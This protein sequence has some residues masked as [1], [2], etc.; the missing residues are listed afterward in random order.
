MKESLTTL[1]VF[2]PLLLLRE[3]GLFFIS[4]GANLLPRLLTLVFLLDLV[5]VILTGV[6]FEFLRDLLF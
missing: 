4:T 6:S 1:F 5:L 3:V 2:E